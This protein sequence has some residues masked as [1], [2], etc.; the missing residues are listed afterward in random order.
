[1][2]E[3]GAPMN[4]IWHDLEC[5]A[6]DADL[7]LW[8]S[9]AVQHGDPVLDVGAGTGRTSLDLARRGA[10]VTA[11]DHDPELIAELSR[12][13]RGLDLTTVLADARQFALGRRFGLCIVPMQT[14]QLL[15]GAE[16]RASFL[17]CAKAHLRVGATLAVALAVELEVFAVPDGSPV[18][19]P[20]IC[21]RD[22]IVYS[23]QPTAVREADH[24]FILERR[25]ETVTPDG[26]LSVSRDT[27]RLEHLAA[28]QLEVEA[29]A[30]GFSPAGRRSIPPTRDY[31]G[32][33]V[34]MLRG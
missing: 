20:D 9:L 19:V 24:G 28:G 4:A 27:V 22:G 7:P 21:E 10:S 33:T 26:R 31:A 2:T 32:S 14:L 18:P 13:A 17:R 23:S 12:R 5:G 30:V 25:R 6:Y 11:L 1:M 3:E 34:V 16:D 15:D 29:R 8:R